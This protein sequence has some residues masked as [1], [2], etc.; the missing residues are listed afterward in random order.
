MI[1]RAASEVVIIPISIVIFLFHRN[2]LDQHHIHRFR[3]NPQYSGYYQ[4]HLHESIKC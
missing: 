4:M 2:R 3:I 1:A